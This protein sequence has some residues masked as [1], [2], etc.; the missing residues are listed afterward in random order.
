MFL[1]S[2]LV[3]AELNIQNDDNR[4]LMEQIRGDLSAN[5]RALM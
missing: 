5:L 4:A 2:S 3:C 1:L